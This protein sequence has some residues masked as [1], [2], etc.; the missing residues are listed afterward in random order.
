MFKFVAGVETSSAVV[1][2]PYSDPNT[3]NAIHVRY[4][5][6][7]VIHALADKLKP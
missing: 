3:F 2:F 4:A 5:S 1:K 6:I 7:V